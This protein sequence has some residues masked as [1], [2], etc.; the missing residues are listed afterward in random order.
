MASDVDINLLADKLKS[1]Q[2]GIEMDV[3]L[4]GFMDPYG[5]KSDQNGIEIGKGLEKK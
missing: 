3:L 5:L 4:L 2:N 1:D